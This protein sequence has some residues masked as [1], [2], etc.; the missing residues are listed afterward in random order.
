MTINAN[1]IGAHVEAFWE[2]NIIPTIT[3][4]ISIPCLSVDFDPDW[5][6]HGY[7]QEVEQ[8]ALSWLQEHKL[9]DWQIHHERIPGKTPLIIVEIPGESEQTIMMYGH[10]DKQ[11]EMEGWWE[12]YGPW[13]PVK[14]P[15]N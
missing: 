1:K 10:L 4:Y 11:P 12:G 15:S 8:L 6:A 3:K 5:E 9:P 7:M 14:T 2:R 13:Q